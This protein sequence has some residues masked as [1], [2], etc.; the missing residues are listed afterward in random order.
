MTA[1]LHAFESSQGQRIPKN[2]V[3]TTV[4]RTVDTEDRAYVGRYVLNNYDARQ[5]EDVTIH[6]NTAQ[7][8]HMPAYT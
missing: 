4:L 6:P 1:H 2:I 3:P 5:G 8:E 7:Q